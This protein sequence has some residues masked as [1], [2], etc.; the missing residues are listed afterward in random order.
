MTSVA[1]LASDASVSSLLALLKRP[2]NIF[3]RKKVV[4][5]HTLGVPNKLQSPLPIPIL[6]PREREREERERKA[7]LRLLA[8]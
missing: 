4:F 8:L 1:T 2:A 7:R 3:Y 6:I 5:V